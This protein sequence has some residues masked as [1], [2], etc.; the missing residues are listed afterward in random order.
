MSFEVYW[1]FAMALNPAEGR[2]MRTSIMGDEDKALPCQI[3]D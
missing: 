2:E 1:S 3:T